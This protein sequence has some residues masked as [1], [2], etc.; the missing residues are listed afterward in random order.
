MVND[1][2]KVKLILS[3][4]IVTIS[5]FCGI[6]IIFFIQL[7][8]PNQNMFIDVAAYVP[9]DFING[10]RPWTIF[11]AMFIHANYLHLLVN[12]LLLPIVALRVEGKFGHFITLITFLVSGVVAFLVHAIINLINSDLGQSIYFGAS[13]A[14]F[15]LIGFYLIMNFNRIY[16]NIR[17]SHIAIYVF[18]HVILFTSV[19]AHLGGFST[20]IFIALVYTKIKQDRS[21]DP[22]HR[23][24][25]WSR[26]GKAY[27]IDGM[28]EH[29]LRTLKVAVKVNPNDDVSWYYLAQIYFDKG[30]YEDALLACDEAIRSNLN[31]TDALSLRDLIHE[32]LI[33]S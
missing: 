12:L 15:G 17:I 26:L 24:K 11:T 1:L 27:Y 6:L 5:L 33:N 31:F 23:K 25:V 13:G 9:E 32:N 20:G 10:V 19:V 30:E 7:L 2:V 14:I 3:K 16:R 8:D 18:I 22:S 4:Y 28:Y 29:A 21:K